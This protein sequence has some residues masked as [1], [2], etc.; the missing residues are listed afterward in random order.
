MVTDGPSFLSLYV[1]K[2]FKSHDV[3]IF[4]VI[5]LFFLKGL[6][7]LNSPFL[8]R[9]IINVRSLFCSDKDLANSAINVTYN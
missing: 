8:K 5:F 6:F 4:P 9:S 3:I 7:F 2:Y 1:L